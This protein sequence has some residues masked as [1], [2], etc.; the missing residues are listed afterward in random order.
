MADETLK[1]FELGAS[2]FDR[3]QTQARMMEQMQMNAAQQV[4]QQRQYD[5]QNK[6]QSNAY[7]QA[8]AEQEF[9]AAE[10]DTFQRFNEEVGAY[11]NDPEL[12][13]P[14]PALPRFKSKVFNQ[15][16]TRVYQG[17]QQY[18]P[19][20]KIIKAREQ[21]EKTRADMISEMQ[22]RGIDVFDPQTGQVNEDVYR[23]NL[24]VVRKDME[25]RKAIKDLGTEMSEEVFLLD[26]TIPLQ[27]RI[28]T[29]RANVEAR[30]A[31]RI[32]PSDRMKMDIATNAVDDWQ[33]LFG[34][35]DT[36]T[37]S[38]IKGSVMQ[39]DWKWP[40]GED[41]RQIR[42]DQ[43][44]ARG[45]SRLVDELNKFEET[46][47]NGKIQNYVGLIDGKVE[48]LKRRLSSAKTDEEKDAY[49]LLQRFNT[50]FNEEAFATSGKAVT[51]PET[52][53]LKAAIGD[54]RSKNFV[55]D[56]NNFAKLA[57][58]NLWSTIDDFKT[59]RKISPEQVKL[60]NELVVKY[61]LPL[62]PFGRQQQ[63][64][65]TAPTA[66]ATVATPSLPPGL[67][68]ITNSTNAASGFIFK[69]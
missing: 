5:L 45:S 38:R 27:E 52:V 49:A 4:M 63:A 29:A 1:A 11:F 36:R 69:P 12:K 3:A 17:L 46:Y 42:G 6:I 32:N 9:Q 26:K 8:L 56:I 51:Q 24:S 37:A 64:A 53:R 68:P 58:E 55:N 50:V 66:P 43:N 44:T 34:P 18:S 61:K 20:A 60:A 48:E 62:T 67:T 14:M 22:N 57:A 41:A 40:D 33:E 54:I 21:F 28:K 31:E 65:P 39:S 59:K 25:E 2:L 16:A 35:A 23:T 15:E 7:A 13:S 19:R 47:G 10:Y 30:R